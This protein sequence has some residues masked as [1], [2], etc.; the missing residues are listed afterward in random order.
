MVRGDPVDNAEAAATGSVGLWID[1]TDCTVCRKGLPATCSGTLIAPDLVLSAQHCIDFPKEVNGTLD[2]VV[3]GAD[4]FDKSAPTSKIV[5]LKT[6]ADYGL[7]GQSG[8]DLVLIKLATPA[9]PSWRPVELP[10]GLLPA[11]AEQE[12][13]RRLG[14]PFYPDGL[15]L[16]SVAAYGYG[17]QSTAGTRDPD[18]YSA[19]K[20]KSVELE[21]KTE[22]RPWAPGFLTAPVNKAQGTCAGDSGGAALLRLQDPQGRG[23]RQIVL[24]VQAEASVPCEGNKQI[25]IFPDY[26]Q[27]FIER[28]SRDLGSPVRPTLSWRDYGASG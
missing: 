19:G 24:G 26:F 22:V 10:L 28:A 8:G 3:F 17:Q 13:A 12:E 7:A 6:T 2:R 21:L 20:L 15:G 16:P 9:P 25:F 23:L 5:G 18:A 4:M 27:D 11:K 1:L 14:S